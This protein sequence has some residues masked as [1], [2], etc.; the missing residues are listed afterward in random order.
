M[1]LFKR[2]FHLCTDSEYAL[3]QAQGLQRA[4]KNTKLVAHTQSLLMEAR[5]MRPIRFLH[6][7]GHSGHQWNDLADKLANCGAN[8]ARSSGILIDFN[9]YENK[10]TYTRIHALYEHRFGS[11][12][13]FW[14]CS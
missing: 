4:R 9:Y 5:A 8:G 11:E 10:I 6:I 14:K 2:V 12:F 13:G 3:N 1:L 7:K